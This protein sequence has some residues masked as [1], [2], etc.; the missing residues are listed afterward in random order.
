[1]R[2]LTTIAGILIC[3]TGA[4]CFAV[5]TSPFSDVAFV[6]GVVMVLSGIMHNVAYL[7]SGRGK[8]RLTDTALVE[9]LVTFFYGFAV[10]NNQVTDEVLTLFFGTDN[11]ALD[12]DR[13]L[14]LV[15]LPLYRQGNMYFGIGRKITLKLVDLLIDRILEPVADLNVLAVD[16]V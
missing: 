7:V 12:G 2:I 13:D 15:D 9:G 4:F 1:M 3:A 14:D 6:V 16:R 10:L 8:N 5:Y 11:A